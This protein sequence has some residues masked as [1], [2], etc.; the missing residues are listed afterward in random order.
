MRQQRRDAH[1]EIVKRLSQLDE[2]DLPVEAHRAILCKMAEVETRREWYQNALNGLGD[3]A[4]DSSPR[5]ADAVRKVFEQ[6]R[7]QFE[8][9]ATPARL[10]EFLREQVGPMV[11][12]SDCR[13][14][15]KRQPPAC[16]TL[17][18]VTRG[19]TP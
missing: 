15:Q 3:E 18:A 10:N 17:A 9:I 11:V 2:D 4:N 6:T 19:L 8:T 12:K 1:R 5:L 7:E 16:G 13:I 14:H